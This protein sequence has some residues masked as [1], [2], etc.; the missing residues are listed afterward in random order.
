MAFVAPASHFLAAPLALPRRICA[1]RCRST[2]YACSADPRAARAAVLRTGVNC[3][4]EDFVTSG[5]N[6]AIGGVNCGAVAE[7]LAVKFEAGALKDVAFIPTNYGARK[8]VEAFSLPTD[9]SVNHGAIDIFLACVSQLD[10]ELNASLAVEVLEQGAGAALRTERMAAE[11]A[12]QSVIVIPE[13]DFDSTGNGILSF[14]IYLD[15]TFGKKVAESLRSDCVLS[16]MGIRGIV[17]RTDGSNVADV[18]LR[19]ASDLLTID[20][21]LSEMQ[22]VHAIGILPTSPTVTAVVASDTEAFDVTSSLGGIAELLKSM[23]ISDSDEGSSFERPAKR[24]RSPFPKLTSA[25]RDEALRQLDERWSLSKD[26]R[27]YLEREFRFANVRQAHAFIA[28]VHRVA[29]MTDSY[30]E[31]D[32]CCSSIHV[33]LS[34]DRAVSKLD[35][36]V[37]RQLDVFCSLLTGCAT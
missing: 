4:I 27:D 8:A 22:G 32:T 21:I 5:S 28:R 13:V 6:V 33:R 12:T 11:I 18:L 17:E 19:P 26:G 23:E 15:G 31:L 20:S 30:P 34:T 16:D 14:P 9:V 3:A 10:A 36:A 7:A 29:R 37:A 2:V 35:V 25:E 1:K 24:A